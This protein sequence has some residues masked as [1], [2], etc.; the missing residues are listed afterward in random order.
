MAAPAM[1]RAGQRLV[2]GVAVVLSWLY[3]HRFR[4]QVGAGFA[5]VAA[6]RF[7]REVSATGRT[8]LAIGRTVWILCADTALAAPSLWRATVAG[9]ER[10]PPIRA[11]VTRWMTQG[12]DDLRLA[13]RTFVQQP[14][15]ALL[16]VG[17]LGLGIGASAA[18]FSALDRAV[19]RPLAFPEGDRLAFVSMM[20]PE[21][22]WR[23]VP[24]FDAIE[25]WRANSRSVERLEAYQPSTVTYYGSGAPE[26]VSAANMSPGLPALLR[27]RPVVGRVLGEAD[28]AD[29][30][31][32]AVMI[33]ESFWRTRY[34]GAADI[35]GR[36]ERLGTL[37]Y[38]I[39]GVWPQHA[40]VDPSEQADVFL[41]RRDA[42]A[43]NPSSWTFT[44]ARL[45]PGI[46]HDQAQRDLNSHLSDLSSVRP[47]RPASVTPPTEFLSQAYV[48]GLW[49]VFGAATLLMIVAVANA[50]NLLLARA[51]ARDREIGIRLAMGGSTGSLVRLFLM[52]GAT[53]SAAGGGLALGV[54]WC[55]GGLLTSL[56]SGRIPISHFE[57]FPP[58][59]Y[60]FAGAGGVF[61]ALV[62]GLVPLVHARTSD[63]RRLSGTDSDL[64][65]VAGTSRVRQTLVALQAAVGVIL[66]S[67]AILMARSMYNL[68]ATDVGFAL[69]EL[70][71]VSVAPPAARYR[72]PE[73]RAAFI[74][75]VRGELAS[76]PG[77]TGVVTSG[78]PL[79]RHSTQAG[80]PYLDGEAPPAGLAGE[81]TRV[82]AAPG[83]F[84][85]M[86]IPLRRG[87][88]FEPGETN[89]VVVNE[90]FAMSRGGNV[91]GR[92]LYQPREG[93]PHDRLPSAE[94]VGV[95]GDVRPDSGTGHGVTAAQVYAPS[96]GHSD[97]FARFMIRSE[98]DPGVVL[99][100]A[101][102]RVAALDPLL[103]LREATTGAEVFLVETAL[104]R[105]VAVLLGG[106]ALLGVT[107]AVAGVYGAVAI[108]VRRRFREAG[109]RVALGATGSQV[110]RLFIRRGMFPVL[111]G[112]A[113][114]AI[115]WT[116]VSSLL[117]ALLVRIDARDGF[118]TVTGV[119]F[120]T[121]VAV[122]ACL[123]PARRASRVDPAVTLRVN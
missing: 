91:I 89:V 73:A 57:G 76:I 37:T 38:T 35:V 41:V 72:T 90:S 99:A 54:A 39:V 122:L 121:V 19:L 5:D 109:L 88:V 68:A 107:L 83:F 11:R 48:R 92:R 108:E 14:L 61:S 15:F 51:S 2:K 87:R 66:V 119:G 69:R 65:V 46:S 82:G 18:A 10:R 12:S 114:G 8:G 31:A 28:L 53:L 3:P 60:V 43:F 47:E 97:G 105:F 86:G 78:M 77:V 1:T 84:E 75:R 101:R 98:V 123:W 85:V 81:T 118:S 74:E 94:I 102:D 56:A 59:V 49:L 42:D 9:D 21:Q 96:S 24:P 6:D 30:A 16:V 13:A 95:V 80:V 32:P 7:G 17:T 64:R 103:P 113:V 71:T 112:L 93:T 20:N 44:V 120:L 79:F 4:R 58:S 26:L 23:F 55:I 115:G 117:S 100:T 52:E 62:C 25:R 104:H 36:S 63:I 45:S 27:V 110:V 29:G 116:W 70:T 111:M 22:G 33:S 50:S 106:L 67:G 40:R 34:G